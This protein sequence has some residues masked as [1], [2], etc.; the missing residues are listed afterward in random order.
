MKTTWLTE[1]GALECR[2]EGLCPADAQHSDERQVK[3]SED[4]VM[5]GSYLP[6]LPNFA[7]HSP[8]G[9]ATWFYPNPANC[10][11]TQI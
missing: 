8:F 9:G 6:P 10:I 7:C 1:T 5:Q 4:R 3:T 2:W 11:F